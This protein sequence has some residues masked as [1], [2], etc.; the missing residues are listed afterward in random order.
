MGHPIMTNKKQNARRAPQRALVRARRSALLRP[1]LA[2]DADGL[3]AGGVEGPPGHRDPQH[4][5]GRAALP[6]AFQVARRRRQARR[7]DGRRLS[8]GIAGAVAVGIAAEADHDALPQHAGDGRRGAAARPSGRRRGAD[9][10]LRQDHAGAA[11][12]RHQ[13]EPAR[14][15]I[16]RPARC[17]AATGRARRWARARTPGNTGTSGAPARSPTRTG[18]MSRPAS[19][20]ATAPA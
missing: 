16:C 1:S 10:R 15:S 11:A 5:V 17:C 4:L 19:R 9:G 3:R 20:A 2:H 7:P 8:D 6:H 13:H 12:G 14:R 18:S